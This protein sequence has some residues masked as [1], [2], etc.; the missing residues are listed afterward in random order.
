MVD[1]SDLP[2]VLGVPL[3]AAAVALFW[4]LLRFEAWVNRRGK[5]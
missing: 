5:R 1:L 2:V 4:G 3:V